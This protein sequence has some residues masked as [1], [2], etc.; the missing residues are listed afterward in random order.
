MP[1]QLVLHYKSMNYVVYVVNYTNDRFVVSKM[2]RVVF[3]MSQCCAQSL[4]CGLFS[5]SYSSLSIKQ[6]TF[7]LPVVVYTRCHNHA[8]ALANLQFD[9][10]SSNT[11]RIY[12]Y[13]KPLAMHVPSRHDIGSKCPILEKSSLP[14]NASFSS[15]SRLFLC[16]KT[17]T[18]H[19]WRR[20]LCCH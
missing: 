14:L 17:S 19:V 20:R 18:H 15:K 6:F 8:C 1:P 9:T 3:K 5:F 11:D 4:M 12:I 2:N 13:C 16:G 7:S 10:L